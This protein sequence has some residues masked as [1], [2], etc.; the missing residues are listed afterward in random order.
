MISIFTDKDILPNDNDLKEK[1]GE[2]Y[3]LWL[4]I[5]EYVISKHSKGFEAWS[6]SKQGW[7]LRIKDTKRTIIYLLP[8]D[9]FFK[10]AFV[11]GKKATNI[12]FK[13]QIANSI[14]TELESA[15]VY[16][17][18]RGIR[19]NIMDKLIMNDIQELIN[20]KLAN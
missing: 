5:K 15:K 14:K 4:L 12:I 7:S 2:T 3:Q 6:C 8:R 18:G 11:F 13:S 19:I 17:E 16:S 9:N 1:L 10:V 20:I